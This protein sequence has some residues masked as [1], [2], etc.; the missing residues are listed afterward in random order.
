[1]GQR[2]DI[3]WTDTGAH[4]DIQLSHTAAIALELDDAEIDSL[5]ELLSTAQQPPQ[6]TPLTARPAPPTSP[7][8]D[9]L[10]AAPHSHPV[11]TTGTNSPDTAEPPA[12]EDLVIFD[13]AAPH[14]ARLGLS[15]ED[16]AA[17]LD[18]PDDEWVDRRGVACVVVRGNSAVVV[19]L[20]DH[21]IM[22]VMDSRLAYATRPRDREPIPRHRGG[23]GTR[24]P[25]SA[26]ELWSLLRQRGA[27]V[28]RTGGG[29]IEAS[30]QGHR[31]TMAS[32]PS[33]HRSLRNA[34]TQMERT[35]GLD[36]RRE[37]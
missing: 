25:T 22:S 13:S 31:C 23:N 8:P 7:D 29:H 11:F 6:A 32:T 26:E 20:R 1:M 2:F 34:I 18:D 4:L 24:Y 14:M 21:A 10:P 15:R 37:D 28:S 12:P 27:D 3:R 36:L 33:D 19:G 17:I 30:Y 16:L 9:R 5:R 35:L